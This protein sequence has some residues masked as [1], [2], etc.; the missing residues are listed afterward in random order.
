MLFSNVREKQSL[1]YYC[2][3]RAVRCKGVMTVDS[4]V[5]F[6]KMEQTEKAVLEQLERMK[7][8]EFTDEEL[9][10][11][12]LALCGSLRSAK[13][14]QAVMDRWYTERWFDSPRLSPEQVEQQ[15]RGVT[16]EDVVRVANGVR[17]DTVFR[18]V[19]KEGAR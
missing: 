13:D 12:K 7:K 18:L 19:A 10:A 14:S 11:S 9:S 15:I 17:L 5:E 6:D 16:R 4:G 3:A 2:A 8:G 1:C